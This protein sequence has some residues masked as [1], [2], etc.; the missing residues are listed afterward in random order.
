MRSLMPSGGHSPR[1]DVVR[2]TT[3]PGSLLAASMFLAP[4]AASAFTFCVTT[5]GDLQ[6]ALTEASN[7]GLHNGENNDVRI[8]A[9][10][11]LTGAEPFH[12]YSTA[13]FALRIFGGYGGANCSSYVYDASLTKLNGHGATGVLSI[14]NPNGFVLVED[15]TIENGES[16]SP[17]AGLQVNYLTVPNAFVDVTNVIVKYNHSSV[18]GGGLYVS[19][20][21]LESDL[22]GNLI[23]DNSADGQYGAGYFVSYSSSGSTVFNNTVA[24]NTST[25]ASTPTGGLYIGG[26]AQWL[27]ANNIFWNNTGAGLYLGVGGAELYYNDYGALGG[28]APALESGDL[29]VNPQFI[30]AINGN[31]HL[32]GDSPL[33]GYSHI[34]GGNLDLEGHF[35]P[36]GGNVDLGAYYDTIFIDGF[37]P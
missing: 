6:Q 27:I 4:A 5:S 9:G 29:L 2:G 13:A 17:G 34:L 1:A 37:D 32:A 18:D 15:L 31:F 33:L 19:S 26:S 7:G 25:A 23:V 12:Y 35:R 14:G 22:I 28:T 8:R 11:L 24:K 10:T 3:L 21:G 20:A 36:D 16:A 30:D